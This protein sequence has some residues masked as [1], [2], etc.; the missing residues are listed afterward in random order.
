MELNAIA[1]PRQRDIGGMAIETRRG[2][3]VHAIDRDPLTF[4]DRGSV[5]VID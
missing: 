3:H 5:A 1:V 2:Q 4:V